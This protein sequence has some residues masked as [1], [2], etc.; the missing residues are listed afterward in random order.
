MKWI[1]SAIACLILAVFI[2]PVFL[3]PASRHS[4]EGRQAAARGM[5]VVDA[6]TRH[7][8]EYGEWPAGSHADVIKTLR[9]ENAKGIV[10]LEVAHGSVTESGELVDPWGTPYR[11]SIDQRTRRATVHS[12]GPDRTFQPVHERADDYVSSQGAAAGGIPGLPF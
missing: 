12:A 6:M 4:P 5:K 2:M 11:L 9:G 8:K 1:V 10:F 3:T 7:Y